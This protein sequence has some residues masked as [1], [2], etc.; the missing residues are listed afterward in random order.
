[1]AREFS[2]DALRN[3]HATERQRRLEEN[4]PATDKTTH[5]CDG[6]R[7]SKHATTIMVFATVQFGAI[8]V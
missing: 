7:Q 6:L 3:D 2:V 8:S 1:M 4:F 5:Q